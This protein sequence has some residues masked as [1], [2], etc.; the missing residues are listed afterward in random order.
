MILDNS[1]QLKQLQTGIEKLLP[2][3]EQ[4][5]AQDLPLACQPE[6]MLKQLACCNSTPEEGMGW[7]DQLFTTIQ[8][9]LSG[10][11]QASHP[12]C[13]A[14]LHTPPL[15]ISVLAEVIIASMNVSMDS[16]DQSGIA[17][18]I[19]E[20][21]IMWTA[22]W[23]N[24]SANASGIF[25]SGGTQSNLLGILLAREQYAKRRGL[26][27]FNQYG[28]N[29][30][31][32]PLQILATPNAHF[33]VLQSARIL[34]LGDKNVH[35]LKSA[36]GESLNAMLTQL[37]AEGKH[38]FVLVTTAGTTD[39][40][41]IDPL[42]ELAAI[43]SKHEIWLHVDAAVGGA[44]LLTKYQSRL[45]GIELADS[46][47]I[48]YHKLFFQPISASALMVKDKS[49][50]AAI[51][52]NSD[53]LNREEDEEEGI[54]NLVGRSL[55]T[56]RRFDA[57]KIW[58]TLLAHGK[59]ELKAAIEQLMLLTENFYQLI[60]EHP[61]VAETR[62]P[63]INTVLFSLKQ[64]VNGELHRR[65]RHRLMT[66]GK[67]ILGQTVVDDKNYLK[68]TLMNPTVKLEQLAKILEEL[69]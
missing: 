33:S 52:F 62:V 36:D 65:I 40:A 38:P 61:Q 29:Q 49:S 11:V 48:D 6:A 56:T 34:G 44:L 24:Y 31:S 10:L 43:C 18:L 15:T 22:E 45:R 25:T 14:H 9:M 3:L 60:K 68:V 69:Y 54:L 57:L 28:V 17:S 16:W 19:E 67:V 50:F 39:E 66:E 63:S 20:Q 46:V 12:H 26:P 53:Y 23:L 51:H 35:V 5:F 30:Q 58:L 55:Q 7:S 4:R 37:K 2:L 42:T 32:F 1:Q 59:N 41:R 64:D 21:V 13:V 8:A 27:A 47:T